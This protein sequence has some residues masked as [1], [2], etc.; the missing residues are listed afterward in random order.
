ME[1]ISGVERRRRRRRRRRNREDHS[2]SRRISGTPCRKRC[3]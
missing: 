1:G 2:A 3:C